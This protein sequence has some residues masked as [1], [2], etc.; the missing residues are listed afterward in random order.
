MGK[1]QAL[2]SIVATLPTHKKAGHFTW[3]VFRAGVHAHIPFLP[4]SGGKVA[5]VAPRTAPAP[6]TTAMPVPTSLPTPPRCQHFPANQQMA[7]DSAAVQ[8]TQA[9]L[10]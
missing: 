9:E 6:T 5:A 2:G 1:D 8:F 4:L 7:L 3:H 10:D